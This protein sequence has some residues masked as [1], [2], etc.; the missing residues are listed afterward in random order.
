[1][2]YTE[3]LASARRAAPREDF[4]STYLVAADQAGEMSPLEI[5]I[6]LLFV[7]VAGMIHDPWRSR[8]PDGSVAPA[9]RAVGSSV[10][11]SPVWCRAPWRKPCVSNPAWH[12]YRA[13]RSR[14]SNSMATFSTPAFMTLSTMSAK[15][16]EK[17][18][19]APDTF[20][21]F[22]TDRQRWHVRR[23]RPS[24]PRGACQEGARG[25]TCRAH[26]THSPASTERRAS[27]NPGTRL[28]TSRWRHARA[29]V[30]R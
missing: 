19:E 29:L 18:F 17:V 21:I 3:R 16:D 14:T 1:M 26:G 7:I 6:Q 2:D 9:P 30:D 12:L 8:R 5:L 27:G 4:L 13:S 10:P 23:W 11:R 28:G 24:M 15:R 20:D 25:R 22:R